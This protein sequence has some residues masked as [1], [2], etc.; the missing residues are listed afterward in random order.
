MTVNKHILASQ[1]AGETIGDG[2][3]VLPGQ[4]NSLAA[5]S[6]SGIVL[7]DA[8]TARHFPRMIAALRAVTDQPVHAIVY[9]HGHM[10]YNAGIPLWDDHNAGRGES[11]ARRIAHRNLLARYER[12]RETLDLQA[13]FAYMQFPSSGPLRQKIDLLSLHDPDEVFDDRLVVVE[14]RRRIELLWA[15]SEVDDAL[16]MW[17][18]DDGLLCA[19]PVVTGHG[20]PNIG[21][22]LRTQR[23]TRRWAETLE[24][25]TELGAERLLTEFAGVIEGAKEVETVLKSTSAALLW[26]RSEVVRRL[27]RG[28]DETEILA[29]MSYPEAMFGLPW[30]RPGYGAADYIVRDVYREET[31]WWDRNPTTL[32]P[33]RPSEV[34]E[35]IAGAITDPAAVIT[36]AE[37]L[38]DAG[39]VQLALHVIDLVAL[40]DGRR[41]EVADAR[42]LKAD[43]CRR[44]AE[45]VEPYVSKALYET[46]ARL[47]EQ[48]ELSWSSIPYDA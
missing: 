46:S 29:D 32:H 38:A 10:G 3:V 2:L 15:P 45:E 20:I 19:G 4:G 44:R 25:L 43:L 8:G 24:R 28:L 41:P 48:G 35:A 22:P 16:V 11:P 6:D 21:T 30:M 39:Q 23:F 7:L 34:S 9:S 47:L 27:N 5:E 37:Q 36:R 14:G 12:Y 31:G 33:G 18:P 17:L 1:L 42:R 13:R 40:G 26:L